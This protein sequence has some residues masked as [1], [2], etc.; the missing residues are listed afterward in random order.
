[1]S[2]LQCIFMQPIV[3]SVTCPMILK[4]SKHEDREL[5]AGLSQAERRTV[6]PPPSSQCG[7]VGEAVVSCVL[8][9]G[10][11]GMSLLFSS[12]EPGPSCIA[13]TCLTLCIENPSGGCSGA[14]VC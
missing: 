9:E 4:V 5:H 7:A 13:N 2:Q 10:P 6:T 8:A 14:G 1:M 3:F 11:E 12:L